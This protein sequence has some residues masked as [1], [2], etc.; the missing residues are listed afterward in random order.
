MVK[1]KAEPVAALQLAILQMR[2]SAG[3]SPRQSEDWPD[4]HVSVRV[5]GSQEALLQEDHAESC[6]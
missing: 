5:W 2:T 6:H 4:E 3:A 1:I